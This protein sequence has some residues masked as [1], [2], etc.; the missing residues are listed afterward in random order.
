MTRICRV[1]ANQSSALAAYLISMDKQRERER[2]FVRKHRHRIGPAEILLM[3][4]IRIES[5]RAKDQSQIEGNEGIEGPCEEESKIGR[6]G[7][8]RPS[9]RAIGRTRRRPFEQI[10]D[11]NLISRWANRHCVRERRRECYVNFYRYACPAFPRP[12]GVV[13]P[14]AYLL[15]ISIAVS[16]FLLFRFTK[17]RE[18]KG[19]KSRPWR[20]NLNFFSK[21]NRDLSQSFFQRNLQRFDEARRF[22][23]KRN[24]DGGTIGSAFFR[25]SKRQALRLT[26]ASF[27]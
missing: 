6:S 15:R 18:L 21:R 11:Q 23:T 13:H 7:R 4:K 12:S 3:H 16:L 17:C 5:V 26:M 9:I 14:L 22:K 8:F 27:Y 2:H 19:I 25:D 20:S 1:S 10:V 24:V